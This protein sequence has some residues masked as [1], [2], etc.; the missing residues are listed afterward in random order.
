LLR[1]LVQL[2]VSIG[3]VATDLAAETMLWIWALP[4]SAIGAAWSWRSRKKR[5]IP[6]KFLLAIGMILAL[7][8]FFG[9]LIVGRESSD[10]RLILVE[11]LVQIQVLHSFDLPR[12]KDLGYSMMIGLILLGV[13]STLSQTMAFG[14]MLLLF[15][16]IALPALMMDYRSRL[17]LSHWPRSS[18]GSHSSSTGSPSWGKRWRQ[19]WPLGNL[20]WMF[21]CTLLLGLGIF[22]VMPRLPGYQIRAFPMSSPIQVQ[23]QFDNRRVINPGYVRGGQRGERGRGRG[24]APLE[25]AGEVDPD[26]YAGFGDRINQNLR[27]QLKPKIVMRVRSQAEGFW[28]V[29]AFDRYTGQGWELS[30]NDATKTLRRSPW[31]YQFFIPRLLPTVNQV[32]DVVQTYNIVADLPNLLPA[33]ATPKE[34]FFPTEEVAIDPDGS[35]RA[36]VELA[37]GLTYTVISEVPLRDRSKLQTVA[38]RYPIRGENRYLQIPSAIAAQVRQE[39]E[40]ILATANQPI[41]ADYEKT[42]YLAQYLKQHYQK[43]E[44]PPLAEREDLVESFLLRT[45]GGYPDHFSTTLTLMLRSIGLSARLVAGFAPGEFNPFTGFYVVR[46][47]DAFA[48]TEVYFERHGWFAF[49][50]IPGY[51]LIPPSIEADQT[52]S[53]LRQFWNWVAGW[54]PSPVT[55][56][57]GRIWAAV[58]GGLAGAIAWFLALFAQGWLGWAIALL[59]GITVA[60]GIWLLW[61]GWRRW[62][63]HQRLRKLPP[64]ERLYRQLLDWQAQQGYPK[65]PAQTPLEYVQQIGSQQKPAQAAIVHQISHAYMGWRYGD[66]TIDLPLLQTQLIRLKRQVKV[67]V[68]QRE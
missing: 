55:G 23:Q 43:Q 51:P 29:Q 38:S 1:I 34:L 32:R 2:L 53:V 42:L 35:L 21:G 44:I 37:D 40:R 8:A 65:H 67:S 47:T 36:P 62:R 58:F 41:T 64:M 39:T 14:G 20:P 63:Y 5:N 66:R 61:Q 4:L 16:A 54:L 18:Q 9:R 22:A 59:I 50:P 17:G 15:L 26:F 10:T 24:R 12:R 46:N 6:T 49:N 19:R 11:L 7:I 25:G 30:K 56:F 60:F 48:M 28:R 13:A 57:F 31:A 68:S 33:L 45:K 52:F 27:G 3:I